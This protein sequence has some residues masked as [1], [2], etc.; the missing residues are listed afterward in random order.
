MSSRILRAPL[1][2]VV[3]NAHVPGREWRL[4]VFGSERAMRRNVRDTSGFPCHQRAVVH[5]EVDKGAV[6]RHL[7]GH[8]QWPF[9]LGG[10]C[11]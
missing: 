7:A 9:V 6:Y 5:V 10:V 8:P 4:D 11:E 1:W 2:V 3:R